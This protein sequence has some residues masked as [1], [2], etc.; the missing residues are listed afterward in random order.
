MFINDLIELE[1]IIDTIF[2][3]DNVY[4]LNEY[5]QF[6]L[7]ETC[8][9]LMETYIDEHPKAIT[10]PDFLEVFEENITDIIFLHF[11]DDIYFIEEAEEEIE[12]VIEEAFADF[13]KYFI[14]LRSFSSTFIIN[15]PNYGIIQKKLEYLKSKPQPAQR[16][17]E[18]YDFR[19]NLITA[20]NAYKAFENQS[21]KNQLIYEKC[22]TDVNIDT[23]SSV[24]INST[25]HWG[26]KYEPL[27]VLLYEDMYKT[28][29]GDFGC[30]QH[31]RYKFLGASPDGINIDEKSDR[32]GRMLEIKNIV[33][34]E[35]D[36][37]PKKEYWIQMQLQME[38]CNLNECD[39][40]ET[41]FI[42]YETWKDF[43]EDGT[44][45]RT[46]TNKL[47]GIILYFSKLGVPFYIYK[48][49]YIETKEEFD[50][51]EEEMIDKYQSPEYNMVWIKNYAWKL[52][53]YS[54]VL[55]LRNK[56]WFRDN[57]HELEELWNIILDEREKGFDHRAPKKIAKKEIEQPSYT[58]NGCFINIKKI[59]VNKLQPENENNE[60]I[61]STETMKET[62][63]KLNNE[64]DTDENNHS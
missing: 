26:Q 28:K 34:R 62:S 35:I 23:K 12:D 18:W 49:F 10:E 7:Y 54:C 8:I 45:T 42:E 24:N 3:E 53:Q 58:I 15:K 50:K 2:P 56:R 19:N 25:L 47:K 46:T 44:F 43:E 1:N 16:T 38:V 48:P 31:D 27:S 57:I 9:H 22:N 11:E 41:Q 32:Y 5:E 29:I 21:T 14:P 64:T 36:G 39:F 6:E 13:F 33:N 61:I 4:F 52:E 60:L 30:I 59:N 17:K 63:N 37:I 40:L 20:S 51:W 55:V